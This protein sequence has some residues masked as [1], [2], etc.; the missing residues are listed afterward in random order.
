MRAVFARRRAGV[1]GAHEGDG[2]AGSLPL[3]AILL[4]HP[5]GEGKVVQDPL[6]E[7]GDRWA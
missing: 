1:S 4:L 3:R 5:Y 6:P 7:H 2:H